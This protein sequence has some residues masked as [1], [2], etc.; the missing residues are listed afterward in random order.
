[1]CFT[2]LLLIHVNVSNG[3][4]GMFTVTRHGVKVT[5][6][7]SDHCRYIHRVYNIVMLVLYIIVNIVYLLFMSFYRN[8]GHSRIIQSQFIFIHV[9]PAIQGLSVCAINTLLHPS[10]LGH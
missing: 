2:P 4:N 8:H 10:S 3:D 7:Y 1:M 6:P 5:Y 9:H